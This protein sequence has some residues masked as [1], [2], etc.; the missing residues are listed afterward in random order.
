[1][2]SE[3]FRGGDCY[4]R[5]P[6]GATY[7]KFWMKHFLPVSLLDLMYEFTEALNEKK[8]SRVELILLSAVRLT[9]PG[10][11]LPLVFYYFFTSLIF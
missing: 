10:R 1:M 9:E 11:L 7:S 3:L 2:H 5:L 4:I 8:L 6:N